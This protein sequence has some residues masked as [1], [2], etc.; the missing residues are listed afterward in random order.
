MCGLIDLLFVRLLLRLGNNQTT[1]GFNDKVKTNLIS[2]SIQYKFNQE[3]FSPIILIT[4]FS[5]EIIDMWKSMIVFFFT[6][7]ENLRNKL[8]RLSV[9][10]SIK[11]F[12][13]FSIFCWRDITGVTITAVKFGYPSE[14]FLL[15]IS[16]K[17][18]P[19]KWGSIYTWS[20]WQRKHIFKD[21][22]DLNTLI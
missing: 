22:S 4:F 7:E 11:R 21:G 15:W 12:N 16:M 6:V 17:L 3:N 1:L 9:G 19:L 18:A 13:D 10:L 8:I 14:N 20:S 2:I 5:V